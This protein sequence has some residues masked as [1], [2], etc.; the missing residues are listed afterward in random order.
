MAGSEDEYSFSADP[1]ELWGEPVQ[2]YSANLSNA[3]EIPLV[4]V[5]TSTVL[6]K[7]DQATIEVEASEKI[8]H[9]PGETGRARIMSMP[10]L[11]YFQVIHRE[12]DQMPGLGNDDYP[13]A[14][15]EDPRREVERGSIINYNAMP[16]QFNMSGESSIQSVDPI[17]MLEDPDASLDADFLN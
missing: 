9:N 3:M 7:Y 12:P 2:G 13:E 6:S 5:S 1:N 8:P 15:I 14:V 10:Q 17:E 16:D 4:F 11:G